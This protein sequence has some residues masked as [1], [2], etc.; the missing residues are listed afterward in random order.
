MRRALLSVAL[1]VGLL[2][3]NVTARAEGY[4]IDGEAGLATGLEGGD[5]GDGELSW[6][7]ARTRIVAGAEL[8][9]DE[10]PG[11]GWGFRAFAEIEKRGSLGAEVRYTLWPSEHF[12]AFAGATGTVT[13]ETLFGGVFGAR[14]LIP[15]GKGLSI[16]LEP[17]FSAVPVGSDLPGDSPLYWVL[18]TG[19]VRVGL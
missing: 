18:F 3:V 16:F 9:S 2:T 8:R 1:G 7:R 15:A 10:G 13:P 5:D 4:L 17:S 11:T 6:R 14:F 12:G 19:G